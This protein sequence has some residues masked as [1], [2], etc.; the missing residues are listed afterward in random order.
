M[1]PFLFQSEVDELCFPLKQPGAQRKMLQK[2]GIQHKVR[3]NGR[4]LVARDGIF[5]SP[6]HG[7]ADRNKPDREALLARLGKKGGSGNG[8]TA[9]KH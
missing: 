8:S 5:V 3:P 4:P 7:A 6:S 1:V 9:K 2:M